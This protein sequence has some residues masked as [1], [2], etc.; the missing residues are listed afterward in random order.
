[1]MR[2]WIVIGLLLSH[3]VPVHA[4]SK[5]IFAN[6][7]DS[8]LDQ[9]VRA[10]QS[11]YVLDFPVSRNTKIQSAIVSISI[12]PGNQIHDD[13]G[14]SLI[15]NDKVV[16]TKTAR[17]LRR[18]KEWS[19]NLPVGE[20]IENKIQVKIKSSLHISND[21]CRDYNS[22]NL[23][24]TINA[25]ETKL[26][27]NYE[28]V[29][30]R[31]VNDFFGN[32]QQSVFVVVP[33]NAELADIMPAV[34]AYGILKKQLP[35]LQVQLVKA[36]DLTGK[37]ASPRVWVGLR[38]KL[39]P[40]FNKTQPGIELAD[41]NTLLIS[42][43]TIAELEVAS[44]R[45]STIPAL[46]TDTKSSSGGSSVVLPAGKTGGINFGNPVAQE[47]LFQVTSDFVIY[48]GQFGVAPEKLGM[49]LEGAYTISKDA[50][51]PVRMDVFFNDVI[52]HSSA[53]DQTGRFT[54]NISFPSGIELL[55]QNKIKV[56]FNFPEDPEQCKI[57][58]KLQSAQIF[59]SSYLWSEGQKKITH[60]TWQNVSP[61]FSHQGSIIIDEKLNGN[62]LDLLAQTVHL[63]NQQL[64]KNSYAYPRAQLLA[65]LSFIP[66][67]QFVVVLSRAANLPSFIL[68]QLPGVQVANANSYNPAGTSALPSE[69]KDSEKL[70][71][72]RVVDY[73]DNPLIVIST[74]QDG[75]LLNRFITYFQR[76]ENAMKIR[77]NIISYSQSG[78]IE[79]INIIEE[80]KTSNIFN[81]DV[82]NK[83][84]LSKIYFT[85]NKIFIMSIVIVAIIICVLL[86]VYFILRKR[87][88]NNQDQY[89][90][91]DDDEYATD[92]SVQAVQQVEY[93]DDL[94]DPYH[95]SAQTKVIRKRGRPPKTKQTEV[96]ESK[97]VRV[98]SK[99]ETT[100]PLTMASPKKRGRP[101]KS[102][103]EIKLIGE[104]KPANKAES[105]ELVT[106]RKRGRPPKNR[107]TINRS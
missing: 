84:L 59:P 42:A 36:S 55:T 54:K 17:D 106:E 45:L 16:Q 70:V 29:P 86:I 5:L 75:N 68:E 47:G 19:V 88:R 96:L 83:S 4:I 20:L 33:N 78:K 107:A 38:K 31:T 65:E 104:S 72:A 97:V 22:G 35:H 71:M 52:I 99:T 91:D 6:N 8:A 43:A 27:L 57:I 74:N 9:I 85:D 66:V 12:T 76:P 58:G 15:Y 69:F 44:Q 67:D 14:F 81:L 64:P 46:L 73:R 13:S 50:N 49:N 94:D 28:M 41:A 79:D 82:Y 105:V 101:R 2:I 98:S 61:F 100:M 92:N 77:G 25:K 60:M 103:D 21:Y 7:Y 63:L 40:Y 89:S 48:S 93:Y 30:S 80:K 87:K 39:P 24:Y 3:S 95:E 10:P 53:L 62:S 37:P 34:W 11:Y 90:D 18:Q 102:G 26:L 56:Q 1:M 51:K 32:L 23:S